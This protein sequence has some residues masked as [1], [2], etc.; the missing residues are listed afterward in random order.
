LYQE[1]DI[2]TNGIT[3]AIELERFTIHD[4]SSAGNIDDDGLNTSISSIS[5]D[6]T[7]YQNL[8]QLA[9]YDGS[10]IKAVNVTT[11]PVVFSGISGL[12]AN[13]AGN[14]TF[15]L[16]ASFKS[17]NVTD[18]DSIAF[19]I[20]SVTASTGSSQ[21]RAGIHQAHKV[22]LQQVAMKTALRL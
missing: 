13:E 11:S 12:S 3:G 16:Y 14:N 21:F 4:G 10:V 6:V 20:S 9:I 5:F 2:Q 8:R 15:S 1:A 17:T 19:K 7:N 22:R 18:N